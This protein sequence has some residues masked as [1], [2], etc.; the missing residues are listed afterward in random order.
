MDTLH[1][2]AEQTFYG[3]PLSEGQAW[4]LVWLLAKGTGH[5]KGLDWG[6]ELGI[7]APSHHQGPVSMPVLDG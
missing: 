5:P 4:Y 3:R 7:G 6:H 2:P 1:H